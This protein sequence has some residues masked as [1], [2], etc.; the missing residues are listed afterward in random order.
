[1]TT[2]RSG[3]EQQAEHQPQKSGGQANTPRQLTYVSNN[4][5]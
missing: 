4:M 5:I 1:M 3:H 2:A